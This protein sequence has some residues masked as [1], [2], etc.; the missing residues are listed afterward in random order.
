MKVI[1][2]ILLNINVKLEINVGI[3]GEVIV[4]FIINNS[5]F[6]FLRIEMLIYKGG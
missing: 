5:L 4:V 1:I 6:F 2:N 3:I